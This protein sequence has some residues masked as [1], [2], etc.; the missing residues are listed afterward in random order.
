LTGTVSK[1]T[2]EAVFCGVISTIAVTLLSEYAPSV[3]WSFI[4]NCV[5]ELGDI[6]VGSL[7]NVAVPVNRFS[8]ALNA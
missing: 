1:C 7:L 2:L 4:S 8:F 6:V 5:V 3:Y